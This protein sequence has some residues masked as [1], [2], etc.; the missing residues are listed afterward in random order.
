MKLDARA[1]PNVTGPRRVFS[2]TNSATKLV[3]GLCKGVSQ[4]YPLSR[5]KK[6][7]KLS[8]Q[9]KLLTMTKGSNGCLGVS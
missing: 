8:F 2:C 7:Q 5:F 1:P 9:D 4:S 6:P 3:Q